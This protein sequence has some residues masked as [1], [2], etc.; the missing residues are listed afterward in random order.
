MA[1]FKEL[2]KDSL[3]T[4]EG[5]R[6]LNEMLRFLF[7]K[8]VEGGENIDATFGFG[9]PEGNVAKG[10]GSVFLRL[11]GGASTTLYVK[12]SGTGDNGWAAK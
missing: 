12:E 9:T 8:T 11:D 6:E 7:D 3:G 1:N 5:I 10:V 4:P 2:T